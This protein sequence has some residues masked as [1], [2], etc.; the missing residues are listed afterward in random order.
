MNLN[1]IAWCAWAMAALAAAFINRNPYLQLLLLLVLINVWLPYRQ[2][3]RGYWKL[4]VLLATA[5][6]LFDIALSRFGHHVLF[7]LPPVPVI[8]GPWTL[9]ALAF[10]AST[11][12]ALL[13]V[14]AVFGVLQATVRSADLVSLLPP[15]LYRAGTVFALA[16]AFAPHT[17]ASLRSIGEARR[18]RGHRSGWRAAPALLVPLLLTTLERALQYAE[19]LD[20]RGYG[21]RR[22]SRYRHLRW[23]AADRLSLV[24]A[25]GCFVLVIVQPATPYNAYQDLVPAV[26]GVIGLGAV[27]LLVIPALFAVADR[28]DHVADLV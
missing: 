21:N 6:V 28:R 9:E 3:R 14:V 4:G 12:M 8:G 2:G 10:G 25:A 24:A 27:L 16:I 20:A 5:P 13:L 18:L 23:R 15:F 19:S 7:Q 11:G 17:I 26:P 1:P 22:R